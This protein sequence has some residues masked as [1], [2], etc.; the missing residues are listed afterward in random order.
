MF[1]LYPTDIVDKNVLCY[2]EVS[3]RE[4]KLHQ[5]ASFTVDLYNEQKRLF[6]REILKLEGEDYNNWGSDDDYIYRM[7]C[8]KFGLKTKEEV[9][10]EA[11]AKAEAN[12]EAEPEAEPAVEEPKKRGRP[13]KVL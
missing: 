8:E 5:Y 12:A 11:K 9:E 7:V 6:R 13:K 2:F 3:V 1:E 10:A 4:L